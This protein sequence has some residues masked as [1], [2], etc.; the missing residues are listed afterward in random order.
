M[1]SNRQKCPEC[2][3]QELFS[4][5]TG[6]GGGYGPILLPGLGSFLRLAKF[7]VVVCA[8]CGLARF[9]ADEQARARLPQAK[10]WRAL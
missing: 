4:T 9:Y 6:S 5:T 1:N 8:A 7:R 3:G 2:G 10:V